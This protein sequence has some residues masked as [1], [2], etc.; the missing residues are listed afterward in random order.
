MALTIGT[1]CG[2][3]LLAPGDTDDPGAS[4]YTCDNYINVY[5]DS[6]PAGATTIT[7]V[8]WWCDSGADEANYEVGLYDNDGASGE[9]GTLLFSDTTN[10]KGTTTGRWIKA[11]VSWNVTDYAGTDLWIAFQ[12]DNT[13]NATK[14]DYAN[15]GG[16]GFDQVTGSELPSPLGGGALTDDNG[17][18][19][20]YALYTT[21][22]GTTYTASGGLTQ[23]GAISRQLNLNRTQSGVL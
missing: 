1:N 19:A 13:G 3:V 4:S 16:A 21:A 20:I 11:T 9:A 12:L 7:E 18:L 17:I 23:S 8:G 6:L 10:A 14:S 5:K 22:G 2:F 15:S